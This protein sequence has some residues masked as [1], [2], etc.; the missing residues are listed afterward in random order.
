MRASVGLDQIRKL[1]SKR[2]GEL[3]KGGQGRNLTSR[4]DLGQVALSQPD[5]LRERI[6]RP[7]LRFAQLPNSSAKRVATR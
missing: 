5:F 6:E 2:L 7:V 4:L 1:G 3:G